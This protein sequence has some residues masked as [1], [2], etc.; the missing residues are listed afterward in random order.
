VIAQRQLVA[1]GLSASAVRKRVAAGRLWPIHRGVYAV[2]HMALPPRGRYMAAVLACGPGAA[3]S[4]RSCADLRELRRSG[5]TLIDVTVPGRRGR[6]V[7]GIDAHTS[8]TLRD[9]DVEL[10]DGIPCTTV[11]RTGA[12]APAGL[13]RS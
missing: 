3:L 1:L 6:G 5:R 13:E 7:A 11:A 2:G 9:D 8:T 12:A 10:V 4:H